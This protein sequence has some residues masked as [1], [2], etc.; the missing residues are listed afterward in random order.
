MTDILKLAAVAI[1]AAICAVVVK[2]NVQEL[3]LVLALAAGVILLSYA[4]GAIQS[5]R[6]LLD[7]LADTAGL[8]PAVLAPVIKTVGIAIVTHVSAEVCRDAK[9]G[10]LASFLETAGAAC[11]LFVALPLVR[12]VLDMVM[13]L[14]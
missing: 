1:I 11:A 12:A 2:K 9:E 14:L 13:G 6:D 4:L 5:V 8:E 3:G 7:M 10:G